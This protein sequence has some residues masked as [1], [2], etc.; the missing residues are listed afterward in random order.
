MGVAYLMLKKQMKKKT[1]HPHYRPARTGPGRVDLHAYVHMPPM[2]RC[3]DAPAEIS[4]LMESM[5]VL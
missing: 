5:F 1:P 4:Q 3:T 2:A